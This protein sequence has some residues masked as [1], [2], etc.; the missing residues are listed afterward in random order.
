MATIE[1]RSKQRPRPEL[2]RP[3][4]LARQRVLEPMTERTMLLMLLLLL[5]KRRRAASRRGGA[6][7]FWEGSGESEEG[8]RRVEIC[9]LSLLSKTELI[10][11]FSLSLALSPTGSSSTRSGSGAFPVSF[12]HPDVVA[13]IAA[14]GA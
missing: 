3:L 4:L 7:F 6:F 11:F 1:L 13:P 2:G 10:I 12:S 8:K 5:P 14:S 9:P